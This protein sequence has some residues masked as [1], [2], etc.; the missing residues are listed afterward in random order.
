MDRGDRARDGARTNEFQ[1]LS[2]SEDDLALTVRDQ[3]E[4]AT[5]AEVIG[6]GLKAIR[7]ADLDPAIADAAA[8]L[9]EPGCSED[10]QR[11]A[12]DALLNIVRSAGE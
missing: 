4:P 3:D 12:I 1:G 11:R 5:V 7:S 6:A 10:D 8:I 2:E 9:A